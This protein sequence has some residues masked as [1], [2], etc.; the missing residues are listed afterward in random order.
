M[1]AL[2]VPQIEPALR[3]AIPLHRLSERCHGKRDR[4]CLYRLAKEVCIIDQQFES[5][6][7]L[8]ALQRANRPR[9]PKGHR[10]A[11]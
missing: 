7:H 8:R 3:L 11:P 1:A 4:E 9:L 6:C 2:V 5:A 10:H